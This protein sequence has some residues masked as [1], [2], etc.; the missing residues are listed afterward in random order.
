MVRRHWPQRRCFFHACI[1]VHE[2]AL[3]YSCVPKVALDRAA[4]HSLAS[5]GISVG[6]RV[7]P[8]V[9]GRSDDQRTVGGG[10]EGGDGVIIHHEKDLQSI[11]NCAA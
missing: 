4:G 2:A 7:L 5:V 8:V 6:T 10:P 1:Q 9:A 11:R 3:P